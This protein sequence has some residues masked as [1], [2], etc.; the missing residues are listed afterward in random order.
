MFEAML[1][2]V[3]KRPLMCESRF[4]PVMMSEPALAPKHK[5]EKMA[6]LMFEKFEVPA[7]Y[8]AKTPVLSA[9]ALTVYSLLG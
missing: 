2:Y 1:D 4:H 9:L 6:E 5:R 8:L 7:F 3:Y